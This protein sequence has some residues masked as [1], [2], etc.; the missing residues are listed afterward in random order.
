VSTAA[1]VLANLV[2]LGGALLGFWATYDLVLL[3]WAEN[4]VIGVFQVFRISTVIARRRQWSSLA[5]IPFFIFHYG[6]FTFVHGAFV[7]DMLA[8]PGEATLAD[9]AMLLLSPAG[10]LWALLAL[11]ASHAV[12]FRVNFIG[13]EE[14][15][16]AD[17]RTLMGQSYG[18]VI[19][20]H[21]MILL[22]S[23]AVMALG[24]PLAALVLLVAL[25]IALDVRAHRRE[26]AAAVLPA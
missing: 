19:V 11:A 23:M 25:K 3:F 10:L 18:R 20:L 24:E 7:V 15:R 8:P 21:L 13:E 4:V 22:G 6:L 1:L 14:W 26:H 2:P 16:S 5:L 12:S 17:P 9:A